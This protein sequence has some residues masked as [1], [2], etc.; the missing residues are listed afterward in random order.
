MLHEMGHPWPLM[1]IQTN[2]STACGVITNKSI[3]KAIK[4]RI[5]VTIG[6]ELR[7]TAYAD[8]WMKHHLAIHHKAKR[9]LFINTHHIV[10][11]QMKNL[12]GWGKLP[13][14]MTII[15]Q[16]EHKNCMWDL[17]SCKGVL[18]SPKSLTEGPIGPEENPQQ[19]NSNCRKGTDDLK[20]GKMTDTYMGKIQP[21]H[22]KK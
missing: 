7:T 2:N 12:G 17:T 5:C 3:P 15:R 14:C 9:P 16:A 13:K 19:P 4:L 18:E 10:T 11:S 20:Q 21:T 22:V 1:P 6:Y 8:Y